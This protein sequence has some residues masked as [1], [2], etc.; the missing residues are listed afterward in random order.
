MT[1]LRFFASPS[2]S[3][4]LIGTSLAASS[5]MLREP[6]CFTTRCSTASSAAG[7]VSLCHFAAMRRATSRLGLSIAAIAGGAIGGLWTSRSLATFRQPRRTS[8]PVMSNTTTPVGESGF[9]F[10]N[11]LES[12]LYSI[13]PLWSSSISSKRASTASRGTSASP[14]R[15]SPSRHSFLS[16]VPEPSASNDRNASMTRL[17]FFASPSAICSMIGRSLA[18]SSWMLR[19]PSTVAGCASSF[20]LCP[21]R[22]GAGGVMLLPFSMPDDC[23]RASAREVK[24]GHLWLDNLSI[25]SHQQLGRLKDG[26]L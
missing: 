22:Y 23:C 26:H 20:H 2:A 15:A 1:R 13:S 5:W 25:G 4:S 14:T 21:M 9:C 17:R 24:D 10:L 11:F 8:R 16:I 12:S 3:C 19:E 18:A 7:D 6:A